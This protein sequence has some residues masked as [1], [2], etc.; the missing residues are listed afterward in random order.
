MLSSLS[1]RRGSNNS[2]DKLYIEHGISK[3]EIEILNLL[4]KGLMRKEIAYELNITINTVKTYMSRIF[5]KCNVDSKK[6]LLKI[7]NIKNVDN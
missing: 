7:F 3:R 1:S 6:E 5:T 2:L 4:F